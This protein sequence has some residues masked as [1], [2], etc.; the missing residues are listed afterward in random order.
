MLKHPG[1]VGDS[2]VIGAG[3]YADDGA[4][5]ASC[6]GLGE[7]FIKATAAARVV[8]AMRA[9]RAPNEAARELLPAVRRYGGG[10]GL[11]CIDATGRLG[12]AFDTPRMAHAWIDADGQQGS[13]FRGGSRG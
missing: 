2:A 10:G 8:E 7:A 1:R 6:T 3:T 12:L 13:G 5:A 4:G 9:G 11:I